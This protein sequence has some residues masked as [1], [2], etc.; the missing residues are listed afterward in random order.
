M[1][2]K[3]N[4]GYLLYKKASLFTY[5][6]SIA[7]TWIWA[8]AI[9]VSSSNA[10]YLGLWGFL[11]FW[12][13]NVLTL[14]L[15]GYIADMVR[16]RKEGMTITDA[17]DKSS[18]R[19][20]KLHLAV[21]VTLLCCSSAVQML[22][23]YTLFSSYF[24]VSKMWTAILVSLVALVTVIN[25]GVKYSIITDAWKWGVMVVTSLCLFYSSPS[26]SLDNF[27]MNGY[28]GTDVFTI[29]LGFG[30]PTII[31]LLS[32]PYADQTFWQR[33]YSIHSWKVKK[34]FFLAA[35]LFGL[36]PLVFGMI[37]LFQPKD[38]PSWTLGL[39]FHDGAPMFLLLFCVV[40]AL[41]STLDS[42]LCAIASITVHDLKTG[43]FGGALSMAFMLAFG[44]I[45]ITTV[46]VTITE[47]FLGYGTLRTCIAVPSLLIIFGKYNEK[48]L[49]WATL[50]AVLISVTGYIMAP[51][52]W[53]FVFVVLA[54]L[55]PLLG[56]Q[57]CPK[58]K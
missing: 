37:G 19:Q 46:D 18:D 41:L 12:V 30:I 4:E 28:L 50:V 58:A 27:S 32:A 51:P 7:A 52:L 1:M 44:V 39:L 48:R 3:M 36:V 8:P 24:Y 15:F 20:K 42:N 10:Y 21:S 43:F 22:G 47:L 33:V 13:P 2:L 25:G 26:E 23:L 40:A 5:A 6:A 53:R 31:G 55:L 38:N 14:V 35:V 54:L 57:K 56:Y 9:F 11:F 17:I 49:F 45:F 34:T 16:K 29:L